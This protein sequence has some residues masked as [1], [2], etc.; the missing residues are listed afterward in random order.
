ML[1]FSA[2]SLA[3]RRLRCRPPRL[4]PYRDLACWAL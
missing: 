2:Y 4:R 1:I 3:Q